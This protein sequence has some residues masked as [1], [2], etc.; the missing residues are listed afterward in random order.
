ML[1]RVYKQECITNISWY[2]A[3]VTANITW[4]TLRCFNS[5]CFFSVFSFILI[6]YKA[7]VQGRE[8]GAVE[9]GPN[10]KIKF[11]KKISTIYT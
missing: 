7:L 10:I 5:F 8:C 2:V 3:Q 9:Q 6:S 11:L 1:Y 4:S